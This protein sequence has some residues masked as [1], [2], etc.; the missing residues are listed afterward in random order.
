MKYI[1]YILWF[2]FMGI[3]TLILVLA[4]SITNS[5]LFLWHFDS[6]ECIT[7]KRFMRHK[8]STKTYLTDIN[9]LSTYKRLAFFNDDGEIFCDKYCEKIN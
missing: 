3:T 7:W 4:Y 2:I 6:S 8:F 9:I 5:F 1:F